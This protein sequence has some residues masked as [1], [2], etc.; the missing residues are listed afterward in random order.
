MKGV[1]MFDR[2]PKYILV[3]VLLLLPFK[4]NAIYVE[5][6][7]EDEDATALLQQAIDS[8]EPEVRLANHGSPWIIG[9]IELTRDDQR[10]VF[11]SGVRVEGKYGA[12]PETND[13][14]FRCYNHKNIELIGEG[15]TPVL[16]MPKKSF[17]E[18]QH[19]HL[20]AWRNVENLT[21]SNL[22][23]RDSGGDGIYLG[24]SSNLP[25]KNV[26][27]EDVICN[28]NRRQ[29]CSIISVDSCIIRNCVFKNTYGE[30]PE[31][32]I[33]CEMN[34]KDESIN[35]LYIE[36]C[37]FENNHQSGFLISFGR[38]SNRNPNRHIRIE[39]NNCIMKGNGSAGINIWKCKG[40]CYNESDYVLFKNC[41]IE[42][43]GSAPGYGHPGLF[44]KNKS[45]Q[46]LP[47]TLDSCTFVDN[48][49]NPI[50]VYAD[51][52]GYGPDCGNLRFEDCHIYDDRDREFLRVRNTTNDEGKISKI[53]GT[54]TIH[55]ENPKACDIRYDSPADSFDLTIH[56]NPTGID[57]KE[58]VRTQNH[59]ARFY[60]Y[61]N[62]PNPFNP[63][64]KITFDVYENVQV[65]ITIHNVLGQI[66]KTLIDGALHVDHYELYWDATNESGGKVKN[67]L[68]LCQL[69]TEDKIS[70]IKLIVLR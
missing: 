54:I 24:S 52:D 16:K 33:D 39:L 66:V 35:A 44:V 47:V 56:C 49:S 42:D 57:S 10:I 38:A 13:K 28:N 70:S 5:W 25:C 18:G 1:K 32:G 59:P 3:Y 21:I 51:V 53:F 27:I 4:L 45:S 8:G 58:I 2:I 19:R 68:Y 55:N 36:N 65:K 60:L 30:S 43:N 29:G 17:W 23:L 40:N 7:G 34:S 62:Y 50:K 61:Q 20:T 14:M 37:V 41:H 15:E 64:T 6:P 48:F 22:H 69:Q 63:S 11:E 31:A 9:Q 46:S 26:L 67:G 12:F